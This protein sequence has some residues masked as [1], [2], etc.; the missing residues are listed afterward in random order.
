MSEEV[1]RYANVLVEGRFHAGA[2]SYD[3]GVITSVFVGSSDTLLP[4]APYI[5]PGMID[6]QVNGAFGVEVGD[7]P[8]AIRLLARRLPESG[9]TAFLPTVVTAPAALYERAF[10]AFDAA[11]DVDG[12]RP[13]GLHLEGPLLSP[14]RKGAHRL[15]LIEAAD[16][17]LLDRF[18][19]SDTVR[20]VTLA[21]ERADILP[22]I[23]RLREAGVVVSLGHTDATIDQF[24][25]G[26]DAGA[27]MATHLFNA[28]SPFLHRQPGVIG[29]TLIEDRIT[30]GLI[31]DGIHCHLAALQLAVRAKG[32][33]RIA[34]VTDMMTAAGMPPGTYGL[35]GQQVT[36][37]EGS[38]RL[39]DGT[40]AGSIIMMDEAVRNVV[41]WTEATPAQAL[42]MASEV[43]AR[44]LGLERTG[45]LAAGYDA[46][47]TVF[48]D[49][50]RVMETIIGG[51]TVYRREGAGT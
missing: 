44:V 25:A 11:R 40:L 22:A 50:L 13:L 20:I 23:G 9:V 16:P 7:D 21:P 29:A 33:Q 48:D 45:R 46:D 1:I 15:E 36:V 49:Q 32:W 3:R 8:E 35:M 27:A 2:V 14:V 24:Q 5:S 4:S 43:P 6:L 34:I 42:S 12:A 31:P 51:Q 39:A 19:A 38:A 18:A 17:S 41:R 37:S 10:A 26:V 47:L 30:A 28:M